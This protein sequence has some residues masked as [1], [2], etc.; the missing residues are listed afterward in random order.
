MHTASPIIVLI[1]N[2]YISKT[3]KSKGGMAFKQAGSFFISLVVDVERREFA[4]A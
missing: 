1:E 3:E 4:H 2:C